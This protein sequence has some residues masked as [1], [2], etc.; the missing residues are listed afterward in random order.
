MPKTAK[1]ELSIQPQELTSLITKPII[2]A[3]G[4][5]FDAKTKEAKDEGIELSKSYMPL[6]IA[7]FKNILIEAGIPRDVV[8]KIA[9]HID[10]NDDG[11]IEFDEFI[12]FVLAAESNLEYSK[13]IGMDKFTFLVAAKNTGGRSHS[14]MDILAYTHKPSSMIIT[15]G[16]SGT[17]NLYNPMNMKLIDSI[18]YESKNEALKERLTKNADKVDKARLHALFQKGINSEGNVATPLTSCTV[19]PYTPHI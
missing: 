10:V 18:I 11:D 13:K 19:C 16:S 15:G 6:T 3:V 4:A 12:N 17:L 1:K 5:R 7:E 8:E 2:Q 14:T 9:Q